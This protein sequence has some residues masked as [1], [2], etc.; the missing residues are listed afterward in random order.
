[1]KG[2]GRCALV[3]P[4]SSVSKRDS[5]N[6][7]NNLLPALRFIVGGNWKCNGSTQSI[8]SLLRGLNEANIDSRAEVVCFPPF[9][10]LPSV[11][12]QVR[13]DF[14]VGAQ[15]AHSGTGAFTGEVAAEMLSDLGVKWTIAGHSE[16]RSIFGESNATVAQKTSYALS[17][18]LGVV[19]CVGEMLEEREANRTFEV[20]SEQ[21]SALSNEVSDWSNVVIAYEPVW[22]IG[23]GRVATPEQAQEVH[24]YIRNW[25]SKT[26]GDSVAKKIRIQ[27]GGSVNPD[28]CNDLAS[29]EDIDGFLVGGASLD[30][31]KFSAIV[32]SVEANA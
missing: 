24:A 4:R 17:C 5:R 14:A 9:T 22:A 32:N 26:V 2:E 1:M 23:T 6:C 8:D 7:S 30:A 18:N 11:Q 20:V 27:Y 19:A 10:Y 13:S 15:N 25:L 31:T 21:L 28:N 29:Q 12:Q 3:R 16:R